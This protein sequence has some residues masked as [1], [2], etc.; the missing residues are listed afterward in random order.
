MTH[1]DY[2][3]CSLCIWREARGDGNS[4]MQGVACVIRNR[5]KRSG[6]PPYA[7]VIRP[8]AFSSMTAHG[9]PELALFPIDSD[10]A[11]IQAQ[12]LTG[13]V[14]DGVT[15]DITGGSTLYYAPHSIV[16]TAKITIPTGTI[17]FPQHWNPAVVTFQRQIGSQVF[18]SEV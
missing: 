5:T 8:L 10:P 15:E 18:F 1:S 12:L 16:T 4:A 17:P 7:E 3:I 14:L 6:R 11:W 2:A 13:N 9:D